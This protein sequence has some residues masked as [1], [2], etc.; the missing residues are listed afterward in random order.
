MGQYTDLCH[1]VT[2]LF[3]NDSP[4]RLGHIQSKAMIGFKQMSLVYNANAEYASP[5]KHEI[6]TPNSCRR[7]NAGSKDL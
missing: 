7:P 1:Q 3:T 6:Y 5:R 2:P 4:M